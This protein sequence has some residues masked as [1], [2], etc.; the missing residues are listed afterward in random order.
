MPAGTRPRATLLALY[1]SSRRQYRLITQH[2]QQLDAGKPSY[3]PWEQFDPFL[4]EP[5]SDK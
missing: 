4:T 1:L 2:H 3:Q 5:T